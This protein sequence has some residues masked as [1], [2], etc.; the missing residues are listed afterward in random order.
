MEV[1][2]EEGVKMEAEGDTAVRLLE[3]Q[4]DIGEEED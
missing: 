3:P 1:E 4:E 2:A